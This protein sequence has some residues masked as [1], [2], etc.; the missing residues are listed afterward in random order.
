MET[1][2]GELLLAHGGNVLTIAG[3]ARLALP[4]QEYPTL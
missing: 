4:E 3:E 2:A 1:A